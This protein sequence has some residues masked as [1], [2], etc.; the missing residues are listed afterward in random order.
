[1]QCVANFSDVPRFRRVVAI[2]CIADQTISGTDR[3][4]DFCE[5]WRERNYSIDLVRNNYAA[6]GF[7]GDFVSLLRGRRRLTLGTDARRNNYERERDR[8]NLECAGRAKRRRRSG[9]RVRGSKAVSRNDHPSAAAAPGTLVACHRAPNF[10][11]KTQNPVTFC[12]AMG[13]R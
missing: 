6:A 8:K 2:G 5:V 12:R 9:L 11:L 7:I 13:D 3:I 10:V 4:N 1:M